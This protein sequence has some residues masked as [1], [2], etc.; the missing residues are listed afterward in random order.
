[1]DTDLNG[2]ICNSVLVSERKFPRRKFYFAITLDPELAGPVVIASFLG[3]RKLNELDPKLIFKQAID[4]CKGLDKAMASFMTRKVGI[5]DMPAETENMLMNLYKFFICKDLVHAEMNPWIEDV[6][7]NYYAT[8]VKMEFDDN[9][10]F[11]Q[12]EIY[13]KYDPS[14]DDEKVIAARKLGMQFTQFAE[15]SIGCIVNDS[16]LALATND[17]LKM[18]GGKPANFINITGRASSDSVKNAVETVLKD[19]KVTTIFVNICGGMLKCDELVDGLIKVSIEN[20]R[21]VPMVVC[22]KGLEDKA[23]MELIRKKTTANLIVRKDLDQA[24]RMAVRC[25]KI[26]KIA[27]SGDLDAILKMKLACECDTIQQ[28]PLPPSPPCPSI[29]S[30]K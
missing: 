19:Q 26:M 24:A 18:H 10:A 28:K 3:D 20:E 22:F 2:K 23:A 5:C 1:M 6:C 25:S 14:Q 29:M 16:S 21:K 17:I 12:E 30:T 4:P 9:A 15:G 7:L 27:N 8:D 11:R 13:R